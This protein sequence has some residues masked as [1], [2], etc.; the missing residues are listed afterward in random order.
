MV[1]LLP[2]R[3]NKYVLIPKWIQPAKKFNALSTSL[4]VTYNDSHEIA[5]VTRHVSFAP[6]EFCLRAPPGN[7]AGIIPGCPSLAAKGGV[8]SR[9][10]MARLGTARLAKRL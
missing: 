2:R 8:G 6:S 4:F 9:A 3:A 10:G 1:G 5:R 7:K